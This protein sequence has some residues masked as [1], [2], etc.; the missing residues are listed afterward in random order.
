MEHNN[1]AEQGG[2]QHVT[3][4]K[5]EILALTN[6]LNRIPRSLLVGGDTA[7]EHISL[8]VVSDPPVSPDHPL[9]GPSQGTVTASTT[10]ET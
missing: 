9:P 2:S 6:V 7:R 3:V 1:P 8:N 10:E 5:Q 4:T